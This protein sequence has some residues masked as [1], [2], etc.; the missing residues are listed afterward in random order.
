VSPRALVS[1]PDMNITEYRA[2]FAAYN[3]ALELA[4]YRHHVGSGAELRIDR[5]RG[6][7]GDLFSADALTN[8]ESQADE[9]RTKADSAGLRGLLGAA[10]LEHVEI[11]A[12]EASRELAICESSSHSEW[13]GERVSF[14]D[15][16]S[17]LATEAQKRR[18][19]EL[20]QRWS[21]TLPTCDDL[22]M[23]R[24]RLLHEAASTLG[25][26]SYCLL[27]AETTRTNLSQMQLDAEGL[28]K[29]TEA[30]HR[31][32]LSRVITREL[33]AAPASDL[34]FADLAYLERLPWLDKFFSAQNWST[35]YAETMSLLG[36]RVDKQPNLQV[37]L[38][39]QSLRNP[40][41]A[42]F[43]VGPPQDVRVMFSRRRSAY[44]LAG[45]LHAAGLAQQHAW[46]SMTLADRHPEFVYSP[47]SATNTSYGHLFSFLLLDPKWVQ[48]FLSP[49]S[50]TQAKEL[51]RDV[52]AV[53]VLRVR[54][55]AAET[56]YAMLLHSA[57]E[58]SLEQLQGAFVD[59]HDN[60]TAFHIRP[61]L[62]LLDLH[63]R[64]SSAS[65][66]RA[67]AFAAGLREYLR[68]RY[69]NRW[70]ASRKAGD[71]LIDLWNTA[72]RYSVEELAPL[73]GFSE[74]SFELVVELLITTMNGAKK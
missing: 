7:Y 51:V 22:R 53:L 8:L 16:S 66:L 74:I 48:E 41:A 54:R 18:R 29:Q 11:Q 45:S 13:N 6:E 31:L 37:T 39:D 38:A 20:A 71:E 40:R 24:L 35:I 60:A 26:G 5:L 58:P 34:N 28:L 27:V 15:I 21:D 59:L 57:V 43:P 3:S 61:A 14:G 10:R 33:A 46:C 70:W 36:I 4:R 52:A 32:A 25:F 1:A 17:R 55:L 47:D 44:D 65:Q 69:G 19:A 2:E 50:E 63:E 49:I 67:L 72:S 30:V 56:L 23:T 64:I 73:I 68:V 42:C 12:Q 62:F 9:T